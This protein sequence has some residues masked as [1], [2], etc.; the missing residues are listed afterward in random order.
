MHLLT[1]KRRT[2]GAYLLGLVFVLVGFGP[3]RQQLVPVQVLRIS[4]GP[5]GSDT[6]GVFALSEERSVFSRSTDREVI[7][8]FQ[9][10]H[11]PGP[12]KLVAQWRSPDGGASASSAID[13]NATDKRFGAF[14]RLPVTPA[15]P[16]GAWSIEVTMDGRPAGRFTFE[17]T[18]ERIEAPAVRRP[19][20][21]S[22]IYERLNRAFVVLRRTS[23]DG[24]ELGEAA[25]FMAAP[26]TGRIFT[27][28]PAV[29]S[30]AS[31]RAVAPDGGT[32]DVT[33]VVEWNRRQQWAILEGRPAKGES[34]P[35][36]GREKI[37]IGS[38]C[39][40]MEG[41]AAGIR[42]LVG[43]VISGQVAVPMGS[44]VWIATFPNAFG[45]PGAPV[46]DEF[47]EILGLVGAGLPGDPRPVDN[48]LA[49]RNGLKGAP[50]IP[51]QP[52]IA[53]T[54]VPREL[55][56]LRAGGEIMPSLAGGNQVSGGGFTRTP[57]KR[58][59]PGP[60]EMVEEF[61]IRDKM[62]GLY[63][64]WVPVDR[65][66]GEALCRV[67]DADNKLVAAS[68]PRRVNFRK[69]DYARSTWEIPMIQVPGTYRVDVL[70]DSQTYWRSFLRINP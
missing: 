57:L 16:L 21:E 29:D 8:F 27:V 26:Q 7:V 53:G 50:V 25:G 9:W 56:A 24:R 28:M 41:T 13:Y 48:I 58:G 6:N 64:T 51:L 31:L 39:F 45:M 11:V 34:L 22:E 69:G 3:A 44:P 60:A 4:A 70:I 35:V 65:L 49:A 40:S 59:D 46:V 30:S 15:M 12:H 62:I 10:E 1:S 68:Q 33:H 20:T 42:V 54:A 61:S 38:R 63:V 47:G 17:I 36:A 67:F 55:A 43:G 32:A 66:R 52:P 5:A 19:L 23:A 37:R 2:P 18:G 14:W